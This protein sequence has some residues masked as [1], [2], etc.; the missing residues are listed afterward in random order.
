MIKQYII[1]HKD[2]QKQLFTSRGKKSNWKT[3]GHAKAA[4]TNLRFNE[5]LREEYGVDLRSW[6]RFDDQDVFEIVEV[7]PVEAQQLQRAE[8]LLMQAYDQLENFL[9][10]NTAVIGDIRKYFGAKCDG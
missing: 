3:P 2:T 5:R 7:I 6:T 8:E 4:F 1:R 10:P 9:D